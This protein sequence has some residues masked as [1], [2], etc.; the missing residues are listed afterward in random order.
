VIDMGNHLHVLGN[1]GEQRV[2]F[3]LPS[4]VSTPEEGSTLRVHAG[5]DAVMLDG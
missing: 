1:V 2:D 5:A 3:R 4:R